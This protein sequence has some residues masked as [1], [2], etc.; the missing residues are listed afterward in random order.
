MT[1]SDEHKPEA[2]DSTRCDG[3][4]EAVVL[5]DASVAS[6]A[7]RIWLH[8]RPKVSALAAAFGVSM[9]W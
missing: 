5:A 1:T 4:R 8:N 3:W 7:N 9:D 6:A 2:D